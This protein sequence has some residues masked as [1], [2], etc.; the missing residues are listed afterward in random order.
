MNST[1]E[2][3]HSGNTDTTEQGSRKCFISNDGAESLPTEDGMGE[4]NHKEGSRALGQ[5]DSQ[6]PVNLKA[7]GNECKEHSGQHRTVTE[8]GW[9]H[10]PATRALHAALA[11]MGVPGS[12]HRNWV[13]TAMVEMGPLRCHQV[14]LFLQDQAKIFITKVCWSRGMAQR[15]NSACCTPRDQNTHVRQLKTLFNSSFKGSD[16]SSGLC[17]YPHT[18]LCWQLCICVT[19]TYT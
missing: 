17:G 11:G 10:M 16:P 9:W 13:L 1:E 18:I 4:A 15:L 8:W 12:S 6:L 19:H 7:L 3:G 2:R 5:L 14:R